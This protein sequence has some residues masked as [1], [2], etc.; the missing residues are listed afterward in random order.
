RSSKRGKSR[1]PPMGPPDLLPKSRRSLDATRG[2]SSTPHLGGDQVVELGEEVV[3]CSLGDVA[4][5]LLT[6]GVRLDH[7]MRRRD[8]RQ[9]GP[10]QVPGQQLPLLL[11]GGNETIACPGPTR[12]DNP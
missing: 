9:V 3:V 4:G 2:K 11:V 1:R 12:G 8:L 10:G 7:A 5:D 6:T